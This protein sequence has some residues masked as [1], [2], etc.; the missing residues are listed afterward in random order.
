MLPRLLLLALAAAVLAP[1]P[2]RAQDEPAD[3]VARFVRRAAAER[4]AADRARAEEVLLLE[5]VEARVA[6]Q[7][8]GA[9]AD[10][11][12]KARVE[13]RLALRGGATGTTADLLLGAYRRMERARE[14]LERR[15]LP[16]VYAELQAVEAARAAVQDRV[17]ALEEPDE[18]NPERRRLLDEAGPGRAGEAAAA[19]ATAR[20][21][22]VA[23]LE[24]R[25]RALDEVAA[26]LGRLEGRILGRLRTLEATVALVQARLLWLRTDDPLGEAAARGARDEVLELART[27][28]RDDVAGEAGRRVRR[29]PL[30]F[31]AISACILVLL[32]A[33]AVAGRR[34][35]AW[36]ARMAFR[37]PPAL[38]RLLRVAVLLLLSA[39]VPALLLA[40]ALLVRLAR[41][42]AA[43]EAPLVTALRALAAVTFLR[44]LLLR[45]F[46]ED[47]VAVAD[48]GLSAAVGEQLRRAASAA[49]AAA[50][51]LWIPR[52][53]LAGDPFAFAHLPRL[54]DTA[55][56]AVGAF[57]LLGLLR[58][59]APLLA[60]L[61]GRRGSPHALAGF[62]WPLLALGVAAVVAMDAL[63]YRYGA[64]RLTENVAQTF[65]AGL[66]VVA[67]Y[68][69]LA[70]AVERLAPWVRARA[71]PS[72]GA[73][74]ARQLSDAVSRQ[75]SRVLVVAVLAG[76]LLLLGEFWDVGASLRGSLDGVTLLALEGGGALTLW[77]VVLALLWVAGGHFLIRNLTGV[78]EIVLFPYLRQRDAGARFVAV[79]LS[80]YAIL[81]VAYGAALATLHFRFASIG[82]ILAA[83]SV[84][85]GFGL[86]E[87]VANFV[88]G[89]IL[90]VERPV[91]VG[92]V[93]TVGDTAGTVERI[94]I[95]STIVTDFDRKVVIVPNKKLITENLVNW[96]RNDPVLRSKVKVG[97]AYGSDVGLVMR[98]L[99]EIVAGH[100]LVLK[101]PP[102]ATYF[103]AF[104]ESSLDFEVWYFTVMAD[105]LRVLSEVHAAVDQRFREAGVEIPFPQRD[106]HLR[107]ADAEALGALR[108]QAPPAPPPP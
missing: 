22:L 46:R 80:R 19:F 1:A 79:T 13:E 98:L 108:P 68:R 30:R 20:D 49:S 47:G 3:P 103:L 44:R 69:G 33:G 62:L 71:A 27:Y 34:I 76:A 12:A 38:L 73:A 31:A 58:R 61:T 94:T 32:V 35:R 26:A 53:V 75:L 50:L 101:D 105:R 51:F 106:L 10:Q 36:R 9:E 14:A 54:L 11:E 21:E 25:R 59:D 96:T 5:A 86:Q 17:F 70:R 41:L 8:D 84:G 87:I 15:K 85:L 91:S 89:L 95:R 100:R 64:R 18:D 28:A 24:A 2:A 45:A 16:E 37:L 66:A 88:S 81:V 4:E 65:L 39:V 99:Q 7:R 56:L 6:E 23:S 29:A 82:W 104:G 97:V 93:I 90:L 43:F 102:P 92:D 42:P 74:E 72:E 48:F 57:L 67:L 77:D 78:Y 55:L 40:T 83:A 52:E 107:S 63:G 60:A